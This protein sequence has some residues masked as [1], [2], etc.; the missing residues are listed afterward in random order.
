[1]ERFLWYCNITVWY[2][3]VVCLCCIWT[4]D[5]EA[6]VSDLCPMCAS[7]NGAGVIS[8]W[9]GVLTAGNLTCRFSRLCYI[10]VCWR[11]F[12]ELDRAVASLASCRSLGRWTPLWQTSTCSHF[13]LFRKRNWYE[14]ESVALLHF[15]DSMIFRVYLADEFPENSPHIVAFWGRSAVLFSSWFLVAIFLCVSDCAIFVGYEV[16]KF[17]C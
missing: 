2:V 16:N 1:M 13:L 4:F 9:H 15:Y 8:E 3:E 10:P 17:C 5:K 7:N 14:P 11:F 12:L 6:L